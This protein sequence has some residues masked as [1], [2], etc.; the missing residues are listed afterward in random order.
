MQYFDNDKPKPGFIYQIALSYHFG[1]ALNE[2]GQ[3]ISWGLPY[4]GCLGRDIEQMRLQM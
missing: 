2:R 3:V 1:L 4:K